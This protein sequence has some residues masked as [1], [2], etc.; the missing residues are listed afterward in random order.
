MGYQHDDG[1]W[2]Y[3]ET[4]FQNWI[5]SFHTG[6][7]LQAIRWFLEEGFAEEYRLA[8]DKGVTYYADN[9]FLADGTPKYY[10]DCVYPIDIHAPAQALAFFSRMGNGYQDLTERVLSW[11]LANLY[12]PQNGTFAFQ[13][14]LRYTNRIPYMRWGQAWAFHGLTDYYLHQGTS[15]KDS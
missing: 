7:N 1:S 10:H 4:S 11:M 9:F 5:D 3:A 14:T 12:N 2:C 8:Y 6:F 15:N 13:K